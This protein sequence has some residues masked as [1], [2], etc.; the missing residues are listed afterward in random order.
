MPL[1]FK[2]GYGCFSVGWLEQ[3]G[4]QDY[5]SE[6]NR[7]KMEPDLR[8][9]ASR[10]PQSVC[11]GQALTPWLTLRHDNYRLTP[12]KLSNWKR[13]IWRRVEMSLNSLAGVECR[14]ASIWEKC[15]EEVQF[16]GL[17]T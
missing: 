4:L 9:L 14:S 15:S 3:G 2:C 11:S 8:N 13:E 17:Y 16:F 6:G 10:A 7:S 5:L 12:R 1:G